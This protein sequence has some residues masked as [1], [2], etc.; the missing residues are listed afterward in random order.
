MEREW[1]RI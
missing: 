1:K